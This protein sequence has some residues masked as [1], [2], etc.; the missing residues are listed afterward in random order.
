[1]ATGAVD[2]PVKL[3][4]PV[5]GTKVQPGPKSL[6]VLAPE[7]AGA[8]DAG[9]EVAGDDGLELHAAAV[10]ARQAARPEVASR[11]YFIISHFR[12]LEGCRQMTVTTTESQPLGGSAG[13]S[14]SGPLC[15]GRRHAAQAKALLWQALEIFQRIGAPEA[16]ELLG[17]PVAD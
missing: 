12:F 4:A 13:A 9:D 11:R 6:A 3:P 17:E 8:E 16:P 1:M 7:D 10:S 2:M 15:P 14:G 5:L